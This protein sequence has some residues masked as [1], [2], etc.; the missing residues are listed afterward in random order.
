MPQAETAQRPPLTNVRAMVARGLCEDAMMQLSTAV[1]QYPEWAEP[2]ALV[3]QIMSMKCRY[4]EALAAT[5]QAL[6]L[7]P[8]HVWAAELHTAVLMQMGRHEEALIAAERLVDASPDRPES[9]AFLSFAQAFTGRDMQ[10]LGSAHKAQK[11]AP[12]RG[13][14]HQALCVVHLASRR[15]E[16]AERHAKLALAFEGPVASVFHDLGM[17]QFEQGRF[18]EAKQSMTRAAELD[19][20]FGGALEKLQRRKP[21]GVSPFPVFIAMAAGVAGVLAGGILWLFVAVAVFGVVS[22]AVAARRTGNSMTLHPDGLRVSLGVILLA[23]VVAAGNSLGL[24]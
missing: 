2:W 10:A 6:A 5:E 3:A 19:P 20:R 14:G 16:R 22:L 8:D 24:F 1:Q 11:L 13:L 21:S 4:D 9:L 15:W 18:G 23:D 7:E 12:A 17:A